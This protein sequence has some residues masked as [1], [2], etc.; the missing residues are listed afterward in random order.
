MTDIFLV[1]PEYLKPKAKPKPKPDPPRRLDFI[2]QRDYINTDV[3]HIRLLLIMTAV[4]LGLLTICQLSAEVLESFEA[5]RPVQKQETSHSSP[6]SNL[7]DIASALEK[8]ATDIITNATP[9]TNT[10]D[11][12][13]KSRVPEFFQRDVL[14]DMFQKYVQPHLMAVANLL[15]VIGIAL[16]YFRTLQVIHHPNENR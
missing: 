2:S 9:V 11:V 1:P 10:S 13:T 7:G 5:A 8:E 4:L 15:F 12:E 6:Q 16:L 3:A 14:R